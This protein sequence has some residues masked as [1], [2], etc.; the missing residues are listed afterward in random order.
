MSEAIAYRNGQ[1]IPAGELTVPVDDAGFVLGA[2]ITEQLRTFRGRLFRPNKHFQ[3]L[4]RSLEI[5]GA[6]LPMS[7]EQLAQEA[8]HLA[9][10]N[11]RLIAKEDDLGLC[12]FVTPGTYT[13]MSEGRSAG[14]LVAMHT[15][16]LP[17]HL[18]ADC[19]KGGCQL[20]TTN[21]IQVSERSWPAELKC[22]S[23][24]HYYLADREARTIDPLARAL[25]LD[26]SGWVAET[27]TANIVAYRRDR[28]LISPPLKRVLH[29]ISLRATRELAAA[30]ELPFK[31][32]D[33]T[34]EDLY[35]ADEV[36]L[37]STPNCLL[38]VTVINRREVGGG[39]PGEV[40]GR[41]LH[42]WNE[43]VSLD[44]AAQAQMFAS[45]D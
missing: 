13:P 37:T 3:R 23:R 9:T 22:R 29:G 32:A 14:P 8:D 26:E 4:A 28:G 30:I 15:Y 45:R 38:P 35:T 40:Y 31:E 43:Q 33:F 5:V 19:Y 11:Y 39:R 12:V 21:I 44:I 10:H 24:M 20:A 2:T 34:V 41:L 25:L 16:R 7:F 36:M 18:W 42:A 17:F 1:F 6:S 27:S